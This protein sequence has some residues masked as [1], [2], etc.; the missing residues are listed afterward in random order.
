LKIIAKHRKEAER[1]SPSALHRIEAMEG[2]LF[3]RCMEATGVN[4]KTW[5]GQWRAYVLFSAGAAQANRTN[6][7]LKVA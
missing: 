7:A 2:R 4:K 3:L 6:M 5:K 1:S